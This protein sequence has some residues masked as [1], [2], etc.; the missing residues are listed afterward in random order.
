M[1]EK[2]RCKKGQK[3]KKGQGAE[4]GKKKGEEE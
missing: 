4:G 2:R 3:G 1:S